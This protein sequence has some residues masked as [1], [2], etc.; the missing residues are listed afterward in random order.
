MSESSGEEG[1][2]EFGSMPAVGSKRFWRMRNEALET[3]GE[4]YI[5]RKHRADKDKK[6]SRRALDCCTCCKHP[7]YEYVAVY[8]HPT[9]GVAL[10]YHCHSII[11]KQ[12]E[13]AN[14]DNKPLNDVGDDDKCSWCWG[15]N[16]DDGENE[17][18]GCERDG[19]VSPLMA[20]VDDLPSQYPLHFDNRC[21]HWFCHSCIACNLGNIAVE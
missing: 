3:E 11:R 5:S 14:S 17:L 16:D 19:Y 6:E 7:F 10:C 20:L 12:M 15:L 9:L 21:L 2:E 4:A 1:E 13:D 18:L 8:E